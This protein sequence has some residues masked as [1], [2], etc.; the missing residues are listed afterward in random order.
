MSDVAPPGHGGEYVWLYLSKHQHSVN[1]FRYKKVNKTPIYFTT[2]IGNSTFRDPSV[3]K[4]YLV[5]TPFNVSLYNMRS[6]ILSFDMLD[7]NGKKAC[8]EH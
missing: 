7:R 2:S 5:W 1:T 3:N 6:I 4:T 8:F